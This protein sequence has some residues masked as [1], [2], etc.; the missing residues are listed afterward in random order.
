MSGA[1]PDRPSGWQAELTAAIDRHVRLIQVPPA[2]PHK[3]DGGLIFQRV[4]ASGGRIGVRDGAPDG[5]AQVALAFRQVGPRR[6]GGV[7]VPR[8]ATRQDA[9]GDTHK[10]TVHKSDLQSPP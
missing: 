1:V 10:A 9:S 4:D 7:Y 3:Q 2:G 8:K 5:I 6:G